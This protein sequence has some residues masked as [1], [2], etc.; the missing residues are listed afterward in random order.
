MATW[1]LA[2]LNFQNEFD[3]HC[4]SCGY[5]KYVNHNGHPHTVALRRTGGR[6]DGWYAWLV[7]WI[8][9]LVRVSCGS[10]KEV[11]LL[12]NLY[13]RLL[14]E[15]S[16]CWG[17]FPFVWFC[18]VS[19]FALFGSVVVP[20]PLGFLAF[21]CADCLMTPPT[22]A[23]SAVTH[24]VALGTAGALLCNPFAHDHQKHNVHK[25]TAPP[26]IY[27]LKW[28]VLKCACW[29]GPFQAVPAA[30]PAQMQNVSAH[31]MAIYRR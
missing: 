30:S 2:P 21:L 6:S 31:Q 24:T 5:S 14:S 1:L 26:F 3:P 22:D 23:L 15:Y 10:G 13:L 16:R 7:A 28:Q 17:M 11:L 19:L 25:T 27:P 18:T 29:H 20:F 8:L 4:G 12:V 9:L